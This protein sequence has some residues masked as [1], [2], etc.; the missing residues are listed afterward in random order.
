MVNPGPTSPHQAWAPLVRGLR[1]K[2]PSIIK[3]AKK[4]NKSPAQVLLRYSIQKGYIPIPKSASGE[5]IISN[6][7]LYDF[8]IA[9]D[10]MKHLDSLD[11]ALVTDWEVTTCP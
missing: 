9:E 5:R 1:F 10:E 4:Y 6:T 2:H 7:Q 11:E 3:L 8:E